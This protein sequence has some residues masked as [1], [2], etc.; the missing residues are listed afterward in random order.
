MAMMLF[1]CVHLCIFLWLGHFHSRPSQFH[2][3]RVLIL[4]ELTFSCDFETMIG[5]IFTQNYF[6]VMM[7]CY[8]YFN[9][10]FQDRLF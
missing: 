1:R 7:K 8:A 6:H 4:R 9:V 5:N 2:I 3:L 10:M